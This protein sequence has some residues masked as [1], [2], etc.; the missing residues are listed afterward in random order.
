MA[1][2]L[3]LPKTSKGY[4]HLL[5]VVDLASSEFDIEPLKSTTAEATLDAMLKMFKRK[6]VKKPYASIRTDGGSEFK[7]VFHKWLYDNSILHKTA[8]PYRHKQM[9]NVEALNKQLARLFNGY[10]N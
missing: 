1:D 8:S 7:G 5:V 10:M 4:T 9:A 2:L 6:Y 3:Q